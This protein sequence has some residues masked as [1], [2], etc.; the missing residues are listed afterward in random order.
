MIGTACKTCRCIFDGILMLSQ[1]HCLH[2]LLFNACLV[3]QMTVRNSARPV[4]P[5]LQSIVCCSARPVYNKE[6]KISQC[7]RAMI[8]LLMSD[9]VGQPDVPD[10]AGGGATPGFLCT[11]NSVPRVGAACKHQEVTLS[12]L[13]DASRDAFLICQALRS[14]YSM[15]LAPAITGRLS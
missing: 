14:A 9:V 13:I 10:D 3:P 15:S 7:F 5:V 6:A 4:R 8:L 1:C 2:C 12:R 11:C